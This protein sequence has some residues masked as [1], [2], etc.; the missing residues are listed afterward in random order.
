MTKEF[1]TLLYLFGDSALGR[2]SRISSVDNPDKLIDMAVKQGIWSCIYPTLDEICDVKKYYFD[3]LAHVSK[4]IARNEFTLNVLYEAMK[5][6]IELC[7]LKGV[8]VASLYSNPDYRVSS[9]TDILI[10]KKDEKKMEK[11][12]LSNGYDVKKRKRN[13]HHMKANHPIGGLLEIHISLN[14]EVTEKIAFSGMIKY[15]EPYTDINISGRKFYTLGINDNLIF[16]TSHYI[17]HL[18]GGGSSIRQ[19]MDLLLYMKKHED[20]INFDY[21]ENILKELKYEKLINTVKAIGVKYFGF[22]F[23]NYDEENVFA[24]LDDCEMCGLF[25]SGSDF[26]TGVSIEFY[27]KRSVLSPFKLKLLY[28]FKAENTIFSR[29]FPSQ[30]VLL[31]MGYKYSKHKVLIPFAWVHK[32]FDYVFKRNK[33]RNT[34]LNSVVTD[35]RIEIMKKLSI[36]D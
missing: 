12:L 23:K 25:G 36:I 8:A 26:K 31:K 9:D 35:K 5:E 14:D 1:E 11:F 30:S 13:D 19:M 21:Y 15:D 7:I 24:L 16:L 33:V 29:I 22:D 3:F 10:N 2:K 6:G 17:R 4:S 20:E 28:W 34:V 18:I 32:A 27:K